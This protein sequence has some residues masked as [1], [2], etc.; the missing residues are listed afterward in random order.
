MWNI[1]IN[2]LQLDT[3]FRIILSF[4]QQIYIYKSSSF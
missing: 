1:Q 4:A 2:E 3:Y